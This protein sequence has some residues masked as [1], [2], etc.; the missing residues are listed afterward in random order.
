MVD[1]TITVK[2]ESDADIGSHQVQLKI[3]LAEYPE[4]S[5]IKE[6]TVTVDPC[7]VSEIQILSGPSDVNYE[8][9]TAKTKLGTL[10]TSQGSCS[11][12]VTYT[13]FDTVSF[14][15]IMDD[16]VF[17]ETDDEELHGQ[18]TLGIIAT[19]QVPTDSDKT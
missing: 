12:D 1:R 19:I 9:K 8:I 6:F 2:A 5:I 13:V 16:A 18:Y 7:Q 4:V 3:S 10:S 11:Y 15:S 17:V 14:L